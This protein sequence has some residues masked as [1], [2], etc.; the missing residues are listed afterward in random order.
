ML[1][2]GGVVEIAFDTQ[3]LSASD[4]LREDSSLCATSICSLS[5]WNVWHPFWHCGHL[6][7]YSWI[8]EKSS[9]FDVPFGR[10]GSE[11]KIVFLLII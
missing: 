2:S 8:A 4:E 9:S 5:D 11:K 7:E 10:E 1:T 6:M 3:R